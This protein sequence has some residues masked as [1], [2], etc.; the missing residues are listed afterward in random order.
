M[1][2]SPGPFSY[3]PNALSGGMGGASLPGASATDD[4]K[5]LVNASDTTAGYLAAKLA[6]GANVT[7]SVLNPG[8]NESLEISAHDPQ[9]KVT[10]TDTT[11]DYLYPK[12]QA[13]TGISKTRLNPG[14]NEV[15]ELAC[16]VAP[17]DH[18]VLVNASDTTA[19]FLAAKV[20]AGTNISLTVLNPGANESIQVSASNGPIS[21]PFGQQAYDY[22]T[23]NMG[24]AITRTGIPGTDASGTRAWAFIPN[25]TATYKKMRIA[26]RSTG[27]T[28]L[29]L[30]IYSA[31]RNLLASTATFAPVANSI[32]TVNLSASVML[33]GGDVYYMAYYSDDTTGN[34]T[35]P[36]ISGR[37]T[38]TTAPL[39]QLCD[40]NQMPGSM[41]TAFATTALRNW[42]MIS[43]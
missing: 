7:L 23:A 9:V 13:G 29:R 18:K 17:D 40:P 36:V 12:I 11:P 39:L 15:L 43:E 31:A 33:N 16:T 20:V 6:A 8:G 21:G 32:I 37:D 19:G 41:G 42:L 38:S 26:V 34:I 22:T 10:A 27:G 14:A 5:V 3:F 2:S 30:G 28:I 24:S 4:H 35:F 25:A 1:S